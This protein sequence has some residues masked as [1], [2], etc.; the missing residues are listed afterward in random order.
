MPSQ[1][2]IQILHQAVKSETLF[3]ILKDSCFDTKDLHIHFCAI[4]DLIFAG[5]QVKRM[6]KFQWW[7][8]LVH[9]QEKTQTST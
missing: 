1:E 5:L 4:Y 8:L 2:K 6:V 3:Y 7:L 9:V